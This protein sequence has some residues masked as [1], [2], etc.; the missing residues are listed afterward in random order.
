MLGTK[1]AEIK[2]LRA[3]LGEAAIKIRR[4]E[5]KLFK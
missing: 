1:D 3:A 2:E 5:S 4:F